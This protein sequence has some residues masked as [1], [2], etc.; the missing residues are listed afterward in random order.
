[1]YDK[2]L[3]KTTPTGMSGIRRNSTST[4]T[5]DYIV[6]CGRWGSHTNTDFYD[7]SNVKTTASDPYGKATY[8]PLALSTKTYA[9]FF[10]GSTREAGGSGYIYADCKAYNN[11]K[12]VTSFSLPT[13]IFKAQGFSTDNYAYVGYESY[14][15]I[16]DDN[17][18]LVSSTT[19]PYIGNDTVKQSTG[20][21]NYGI[22]HQPGSTNIKVFEV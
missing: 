12:V 21:K 2:N 18:V 5:K 10:G 4:S 17:L 19:T 6:C 20:F 8:Y 9:I 7:N 14:N 22:I 3:T 1:M 11:N 13:A 16:Y 15:F